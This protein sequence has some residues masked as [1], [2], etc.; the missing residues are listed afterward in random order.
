MHSGGN[1]SADPMGKWPVHLYE[2]GNSPAA[3]MLLERWDDLHPAVEWLA[4]RLGYAVVGLA[5]SQ[6]TPLL[7]QGDSWAGVGPISLDKQ[8]LAALPGCVINIVQFQHA[9]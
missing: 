6:T 8:H 9:D 4:R 7:R 1:W 2:S 3:A 5:F